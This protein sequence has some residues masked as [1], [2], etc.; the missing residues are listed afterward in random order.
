M[1]GGGGWWDFEVWPGRLSGGRF[2]KVLESSGVLRCRFRRLVPEGSGEFRR[3]AVSSATSRGRAHCHT[4]PHK[5]TV[6]WQSSLPH[7]ATQGYGGVAELTATHCHTRVRWCGRAH[8]HTLPR[9]VAELTH[10]L[11]TCTATPESF[12]GH[13]SK[14]CQPPPAA[15]SAT[16]ANPPNHQVLSG[17]CLG[18]LAERHVLRLSILSVFASRPD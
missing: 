15:T 4:L 3:V 2:W 12:P 17:C 6:A 11:A 13:T 8:C 14:S 9:D 5:G 7:T 16:I 18:F 1:T 10:A